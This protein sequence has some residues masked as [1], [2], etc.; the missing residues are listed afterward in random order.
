MTLKVTRYFLLVVRSNNVSILHRFCDITTFT[1]YVTACDLEKAFN[2]HT[3]VECV[4]FVRLPINIVLF[5]V[6]M[7]VA[8]VSKAKVTTQSLKVF[9]LG[10]INRP[11]MTSY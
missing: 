6:G 7:G 4:G 5:R 10:A 8:K 11:L 3:A 9:D 2:F 1:V